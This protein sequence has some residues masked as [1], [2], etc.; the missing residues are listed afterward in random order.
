[1]NIPLIAILATAGMIAQ[2]QGGPDAGAATVTVYVHVGFGGTDLKPVL[3][4]SIASA[5]FAR[6]GVRIQ[7]RRER[8]N[9]DQQPYRASSPIVVDITSHASA[10]PRPDALAFAQ[11][12]EGVHIKVFWDRVKES[13]NCNPPL[14]HKLL[15]N[16]MVHEITHVL[17]GING[18]SGEGIMK[19]QWTNSDI[20]QMERMPLLFSRHDIELIH[21]GLKN[22]AIARERVHAAARA[23]H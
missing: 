17:Q 9:L 4:E 12:Y 8:L 1:M 19:A 7:W 15:A 10:S 20:L 6:A 11:V 18:H 22:R 14:S 23:D 2:A 5:M 16:V 13:A 21:E 3:A